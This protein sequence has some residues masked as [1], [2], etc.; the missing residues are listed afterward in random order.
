M[1][2]VAVLAIVGGVSFLAARTIQQRIGHG[3][4]IGNAPGHSLRPQWAPRTAVLTAL[5]TVAVFVPLLVVTYYALAL[6]EHVLGQ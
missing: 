2:L 3:H 6:V 5:L 4:L 1:V